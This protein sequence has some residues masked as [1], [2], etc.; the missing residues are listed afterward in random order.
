VYI[1]DSIS[2]TEKLYIADGHHRAASAASARDAKK[3][4]TKIIKEMK[5]I[6]IS[7]VSFSCQS[8]KDT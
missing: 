3:V 1:I 2:R 8:V 5:S 6:I 4:R 7:L